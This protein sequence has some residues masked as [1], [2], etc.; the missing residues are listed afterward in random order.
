M[1]PLRLQPV[2]IKT[3]W[4]GHT[5]HDIRSLPEEGIGIAREVCAYKNSENLIA[6]GE[7]QG[8]SIKELIQEHHEELMGRDDSNQLIRAAYIDA[9]EDLSIQVHPKETD[10]AI[11]G[12]Y[13]KSE[14][15]YIVDAKEGASIVAGTTTTDKAVL[16][17]AIEEGTLEKY[18]QRIPVKKGDF[19]LIP[20]GL[21][22]ACGKD[23]LAIEIGSFGGITYRL[24]DYGRPRPLDLEKGFA[25][26]DCDEAC[27]MTHHPLPDKPCN[28]RNT[29]VDHTLFHVDVIDIAKEGL[30][31]TNNQYHVIVCVDGS[32]VV[33]CKG[34]AFALN[35][36]QTLLIPA[37]AKQYRIKGNLRI[38]QGWKP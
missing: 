31:E 8:K 28:Q 33:E 20:A 37:S 17:K 4:A 13:E 22:H 35:Y 14:S 32:G 38:L 25:V 19:A 7:Y 18:I 30:F 11:L 16:K 27:S 36:T 12:D 3:I 9:I 2:Y 21:L 6:E 5:L 24:Y 29:G 15:W 23:M 26:L 10:A 34:E 1:K